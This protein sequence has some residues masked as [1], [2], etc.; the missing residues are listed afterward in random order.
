MSDLSKAHQLRGKGKKY[1]G[2]E[3]VS[4]AGGRSGAEGAMM[5]QLR[6]RLALGEI[7]NIRREQTIQL[8]PSMAHKLDFIFWDYKRGSDIGIEIHFFQ[9]ASWDEK[10]KCYRDFTAFPVQIWQREK[11]RLIMMKEIPVGKY[12]IVAKQPGE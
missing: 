6:A 4:F 1:L 9:N 12:K 5:E 11:G 3:G 8:T 2:S 10:E 7:A